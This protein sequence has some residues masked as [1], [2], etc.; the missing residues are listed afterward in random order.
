MVTPLPLREAVVTTSSRVV[1]AGFILVVFVLILVAFIRGGRGERNGKRDAFQMRVTIAEITGRYLTTFTPRKFWPSPCDAQAKNLE[2]FKAR[3]K[4]M[5]YSVVWIFLLA[6]LFCAGVFLIIA[7]SAETIEV[8]REDSHFVAAVCVS[9]ALFLCGVWI[10]LFRMGS[11]TQ[12]A[13]KAAVEANNRVGGDER[14]AGDPLAPSKYARSPEFDGRKRA[15]LWIA[16]FVLLV[17]WLLALSATINIRAWTLPGEQY[18]TLFFLG[19]GYGLFTGWLAFATTL[20][21]GIALY[22]GS[23]PDCTKPP[24]DDALPSK[25]YKPSW[26]PAFSAFFLM[27]LPAVIIPDPAQPFLMVVALVFFTP[28]FSPNLFAAGIGVVGVALGAWR[29]YGLRQELY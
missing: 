24:P 4:S 20:N 29:V 12:E 28:R 6:W 13:L 11:Q 14:A 7:G 3:A 17:A 27:F 22:A 23:Y 5:L 21:F 19:P 10:I 1:L 15:W 26:V 2:N 9:A 8:F 25:A 18:G 16:F